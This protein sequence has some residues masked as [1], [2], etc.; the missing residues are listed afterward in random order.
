MSKA[1]STTLVL[2][3][4]LD[5]TG[6]VF[7]PLLEYL[8]EDVDAQIVRYPTDRVMSLQEHVDFARKQL[9][10]KK[11]FVL[12][13][14][15]FSGPIGLQLL[16]EPPGN[17]V[18][19]IF[20]ATFVRYPSPFFL[21]LG[22][23]LPQ[24]LIFNLFAKSPLGRLFCLGGASADAVAIFREALESVKLNVLSNRLKILAE[25]PPPPETSFSG[26]CLYLQADK[27]RLIPER[28]VIP[29]QQ[30]LPQLQ[31]EQTSGPHIT[32]LAHPKSGARLISEFIAGLKGSE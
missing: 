8:P 29:L 24:T 27:D 23:H 1:N 5:G 30:H 25:L 10:R 16:S 6:L 13:A 4:G 20:V 9:P 11:P 21:D 3:P 14:E 17:L 2:L 26:P 7:E 12:L 18:G 28:A 31:I 15:S 22:L 32:L 19:V